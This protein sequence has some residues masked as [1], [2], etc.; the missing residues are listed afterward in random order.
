MVEF[1]KI[2]LP[3][4][5]SESAEN[6]SDYAVYL[7]EKFGSKIYVVHVVEPLTYTTDLGLDFGD[8]YSVM[9]TT[10][11]KFLEETVA[12]IK[13]KNSDVEG[14]LLAGDP[15]NEIIRFAAQ[16]QIDVI[17]MATHGRKGIE[18]FLLGSVAEKV[19]RKSPCPVLTVKRAG[20]SFSAQ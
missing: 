18:H 9:E 17:I 3:T 8:Q 1:G 12:S 5:F 6:A 4:D 7:A 10:A 19:V 13:E 2:L 11:K 20:Q 14:I 15:S 16:E